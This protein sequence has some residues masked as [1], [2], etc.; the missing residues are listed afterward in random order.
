MLQAVPFASKFDEYV[1]VKVADDDSQVQDSARPGGGSWSNL[2][3]EVTEPGSYP[4]EALRR[5]C[6]SIVEKACGERIYFMRPFTAGTSDLFDNL[7]EAQGSGRAGGGAVTVGML[8]NPEYA[9]VKIDRGPAADDKDAAK[10]FR[11]AGTLHLAA[12]NLKPRCSFDT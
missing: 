11:S 9:Y 5:A 2:Y 7:E 8:L 4:A 3:G 1:R 12:L 6:S 10:A